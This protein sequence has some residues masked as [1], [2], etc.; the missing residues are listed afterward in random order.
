MALLNLAEGRETL[1][2]PGA[3]KWP[4]DVFGK[5]DRKGEGGKAYLPSTAR[6]AT[7]PIPIAGPN[8]T[9]TASAGSR[10]ELGRINTWAPIPGSS[11]DL[12]PLRP[13]WPTSKYLPAAVQGQAIIPTENVRYLLQDVT[14]T[15]A[16]AKLK[17]NEERAA[18]LNGYR[19]LLPP[20]LHR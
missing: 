5:I 10:S 14:S 8:R 7:T 13:H 4:E 18:K 3:P 20:P 11:D 19:D 2:A 15:E 17:L 16:M 1:G 6:A 9:S 12:E